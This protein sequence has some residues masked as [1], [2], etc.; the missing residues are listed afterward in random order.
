MN[1]SK[2]TKITGLPEDI[3]I[4][5]IQQCLDDK[6]MHSDIKYDYYGKRVQRG[7]IVLHTKAGNLKATFKCESNWLTDLTFTN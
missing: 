7:S 4:G 5:H 6:T 2:N 1:I 3:S